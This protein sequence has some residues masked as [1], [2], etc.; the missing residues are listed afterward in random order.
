VPAAAETAFWRPA[1]LSGADLGCLLGQPAERL[2]LFAC[3]E[4]C[5]P[6]A[7]QLDERD[8]N[9][10]LALDRGPE[11]NPDDPPG[12]V[13][14]NDEIL[15]MLGDA[16]RQ[17]AA[18]ELPAAATCVVAVRLR[19]ATFEGWAYAVALPHPPAPATRYVRYDANADRADAAR[20]RV[21]F[22]GPTPRYFALLSA[23]GEAGENLLD[24]LKVRAYARFL[25]LIPLWRD[26]DDLATEF[27]AWRAGP[28]RVVRRQRQWVRLGWGLRTPIFRNDA[29]V[30][31]DFSELPVRLRL[32][33]PPTYFFRGI[34]IDGILDFRALPGWRLLAEGMSAPAAIGSL[35]RESRRRL[36][37]LAGDWFALAADDGLLVQTLTLSPSLASVTRSLVYREDGGDHGPEAVRGENPGVGVRLTAWSEVDR[38]DHWFVSTSYALPAAY[39]VARFLELNRAGLAVEAFSVDRGAGDREESEGLRDDPRPGEDHAGGGAQGGEGEDEED[40]QQAVRPPA[41]RRGKLARRAAHLADAR[42]AQVG[43]H[44][45]GDVAGADH[46]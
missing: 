29:F 34:R 10:E 27:V 44:E 9:G 39:D 23:A 24:R 11:P 15:W 7:W 31:R 2:A 33:F 18:E 45:G 12:V 21:G 35:D 1:R 20:F 46:G 16:G 8:G 17:V 41:A 37:R 14:A 19:L 6:I 13:D 28:I 26:E 5:R 40:A 4:S 38:G 36:N 22:R 43:L 25:G 3:A 42:R 30:Y 32:N